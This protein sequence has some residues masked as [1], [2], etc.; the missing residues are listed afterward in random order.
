MSTKIERVY[1]R[2]MYKE[3]LAQMGPRRGRGAP[4][5]DSFFRCRSDGSGGY[6]LARLMSSRSGSGGGRGGRTRVSLYLSLIWVAS[7]KDHSSQRPARYWAGLLGLDD[8]EHAG[9]R[10]VSN[11]WAELAARNLV[12]MTPGQYTGDVPTVRLL[13]EDGSGE[14]Y[15]IP[16]GRDGDTYRRVPESVWESLIPGAMVTGAGLAMYLVALRTAYIKGELDGL[17]FPSAHFREEYGLGESTRKSGL[18]NLV[19]QGVLDVERQHVDGFGQLGGRIRS[20]NLYDL[21]GLYGPVAPQPA[22]PTAT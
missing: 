6:P 5:R 22:P 21:L 10:V 11:T 4:L 9:A 18:R 14:P 12:S 15:T 2:Q 13:R 8:P 7:G 20:R 1:Q 19:D 16:T 17:A 3:T